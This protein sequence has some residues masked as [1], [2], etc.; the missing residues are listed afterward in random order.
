M[1]NILILIESMNPNDSSGIKG[2]L[3]LINNL[4][5]IGYQ[6]KV[7]HLDENYT[8][9]ESFEAEVVGRF[10]TSIYFWLSKLNTFAKSLN[11]KLNKWVEPQ[12]GFSFSHYED[13]DRFKKALVRETPDHYDI[14][15]TLSKAASFR[16]HKAVL[17]SPEWHS[18]W[19]AYVHDPY[20]M[21]VYPRPYDW[22]EPGSLLKR[23]FFLQV[24][25]KAKKIAYPS[26][27]LAEWMESYYPLGMAK[28]AIIPHQIPLNLT[29][30]INDTIQLPDFFDSKKFTVLHAGSLMK[31]RPPFVLMKA[32]NLFLANSKEPNV[33]AQLIFVGGASED[34]KIEVKPL[35]NKNITFY[36]SYLPFTTVF[37][38]QK[39]AT[40]NVVIE[41][42]AR[43]SPFLPG[44]IPH[45]VLAKKPILHIGPKVSETIRLLGDNYP[46]HTL[47]H[48]NQIETLSDKIA[49][50][51]SK[52]ADK[53]QSS[54]NR[55]DLENY[56]SKIKL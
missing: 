53:K 48:P 25:A 34:H 6:V 10:P 22:A 42:N 56:F 21:Y 8:N 15:F 35:L 2:R 38:L 50:I 18:R 27:L 1:Y 47:N 46:L 41:A 5:K 37:E 29:K 14:V 23:A 26:L 11:I 31:Q 54:M 4:I 45:L 39:Q 7:I 36:G 12:F 55:K 9:D 3:A 33:N 32:F 51:Y 40:L 13:V 24:Y 52:W 30:E 28:R 43:I 49:S 19:Y 17:E 44:K 20:P 16:P